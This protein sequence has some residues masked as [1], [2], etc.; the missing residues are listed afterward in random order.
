MP[1]VAEVELGQGKEG[2]IHRLRA[3]EL[4]RQAVG[5]LLGRSAVLQLLGVGLHQDVNLAALVGGGLEV[6]RVDQQPAGLP[7]VR[8]ESDFIGRPELPGELQ[9]RARVVGRRLQPADERGFL[10]T[11]FLHPVNLAVFVHKIEQARGAIVAARR[12]RRDRRL[13]STPGRVRP[14][15]IPVILIRAQ[16]DLQHAEVQGQLEE[17]E[18]LRHGPLVPRSQVRVATASRRL[19]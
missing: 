3:G 13:V 10:P 1:P 7:V 14:V 6:E 17:P 18:H 2:L 5:V 16:L 19:P 12:G 15:T 4:F 11:G 8:P 9:P